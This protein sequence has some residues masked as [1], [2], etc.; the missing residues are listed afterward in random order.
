[1]NI[2]TN[3]TKN[4]TPPKESPSKIETPEFTLDT[5]TKLEKVVENMIKDKGYVFTLS[6]LDSILQ[7]YHNENQFFGNACV[8]CLK[9]L[10]LLEQKEYSLALNHYNIS[11]SLFSKLNLNEYIDQTLVKISILHF[12]EGDTF[13]SEIIFKS[14]PINHNKSIYY[15]FILSLH[16]YE[17][18]KYL[19]SKNKLLQIT[20]SISTSF[21][22]EFIRHKAYLMLANIELIEKKFSNSLNYAN[23]SADYFKKENLNT[24]YSDV[25]LFL[26]NLMFNMSNFEKQEEYFNQSITIK[27]HKCF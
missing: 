3:N 24:S 23:I 16:D 18:K 12:M 2:L 25:L 21:E 5:Y 7:F 26:S 4:Q 1:M 27:K 8:N 19:N 6:F 13:R 14:I 10:I 20:K 11:L 9:S 22:E 17:N 15:N